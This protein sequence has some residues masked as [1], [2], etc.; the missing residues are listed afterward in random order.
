[1]AGIQ[2]KKRLGTNI[3]EYLVGRAVTR[4][5][6]QRKIWGSKVGPVILDTVLPTAHHR[7]NNSIKHAEFPGRNDAEMSPANSLLALAWYS[8]HDE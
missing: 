1:M 6:L 4:S 3:T 5:F 2:A 7:C 8:E